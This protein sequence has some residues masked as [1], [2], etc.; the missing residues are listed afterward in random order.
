MTVPAELQKAIGNRY[1]LQRELGRGGMATVYL[2]HD[3]IN[4]RHVAIKI[5]DP[6]QR[7]GAMEAER[8]FREIKIAANLVHPG[9]VPLFDSGECAGALYYV[10]PVLQSATLGERLQKE[11][12]LDV[13]EAVRIAASVARAL[14]YAHRQGVVHRDIKP[15]NIFLQE[16]E[17]TLSDFGVARFGADAD[18]RTT[19]PG[20][21]VGTPHYMSPEQ[22]AGES[23]IDG[24]SDQYSLACVLYEMLAGQP[25]FTGTT[26]SQVI[27][28]RFIETP[29]PIR[30]QRP[31][32][33]SAVEAALARA[34]S[35]DPNERFATAGEFAAAL[36]ARAVT[37][38]SSPMESACAV[39]V[40][41]FVTVGGDADT[42]YLS[43]GLTDELISALTRVEGLRVASRT[44]VFT[45]K[46]RALDVR[47]IA[48]DLGVDCVI[49]GSVRQMGR[50]LRVTARLTNA[51]DG[52]LQRSLRYDRDTDD[53]FALEDELAAEIVAALSP[54]LLPT[55]VHV[56]A[57]R[58]TDNAEAYRHYLRG[59]FAWNKRTFEDTV[60]A[61]KHFE[62]AIAEDPTYALAYSGLSDAHALQLDYRNVAVA[63]GMANAKKY[64]YKALELDEALAEAHASLGWVLFI[65]DWDFTASIKH[66]ERAVSLSPG[67]AT[68]HQWYSFP[69]VVQGQFD[70]AT[71]E[72]QLAVDLDPSSVS[73]RRS[74]GGVA[75]YARR[76]EESIVHLDR[77][78]AINPVSEETHRGLGFSYMHLGELQKAER[79]FR[80]GLLYTPES[81]YALAGLVGVLHRQGRSDEALA[82][83][84]ELE[85][86]ART[87]YVSSAA[88]VMLHA[89]L[90]NV[91]EAVDW[92]YKARDERRGFV[93][94][95]GVNPTLDSLRQSPRFNALLAELSLTRIPVGA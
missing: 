75:Y 47:R 48:M 83:Q 79:A 46:G 87:E 74:R 58:Y 2:A 21:A 89:A 90:G 9:I 57:P 65:H 85:K 80:E 49:E 53:L 31:S 63:E 64:A 56:A 66:F 25:P 59:R 72:A 11:G 27:M 51:A 93:V 52:R 71:M 19:T 37:T 7:S 32:V 84:H 43:D 81:A 82:I 12:A 33:S 17:P 14:D 68:T 77:A 42:E 24:R 73:A 29:L 67:Y 26:A 34:L 4:A 36:S 76:Y 22:A 13:D 15:S 88:F 3:R 78:A 18:A 1:E 8:F 62:A 28:R 70:R 69:L 6:A 23:E 44:S 50:R 92:L 45:Y 94:Y 30:R 10:M 5:L 40:L 16:G 60:E 55:S 61:I 38:T 86:R 54:T 20:L 41:P 35:T 39:A 95:I 91:E